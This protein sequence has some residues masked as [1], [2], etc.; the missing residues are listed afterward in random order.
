MWIKA[1]ERLSVPETVALY[2]IWTENN[3]A[4]LGTVDD[5]GDSIRNTRETII[6]YFTGFLNKD[7]I[8]AIFPDVT[9]ENI[10]RLGQNHVIYSGY[11]TFFLTKDGMTS[12]VKAKFS[13]VYIRKPD[14]PHLLITTHNSG[15]TPK[16]VKTYAKR[17]SYSAPSSGRPISLDKVRE[18]RDM[19]IKAVESR[20]V[21]EMVAL[22]DETGVLLG[23]VDDEENDMRNNKE[24][25]AEYFTAFLD[26]DEIMTSFPDVT[27]ENIIRLGQNHVIYSGYY[28]FFLTKDDIITEVKAK[29]SYVY[30]RKPGVPHLL[31]TTHNSGITPMGVKT[32]EKSVVAKRPAGSAPTQEQ[33]QAIARLNFKK[34]NDALQTKDHRAVAALYSSD[35]LSFL[36]TVSAS[37]IKGSS[38]TE[39]YFKAFVQRNPF[40]TITHDT[41]QAYDNGN[42]YLHSGMYTFGLGSGSERKPVQA[43]FS[44]VWKKIGKEWKITHHH[45]SI[46]PDDSQSK[47]TI[48]DVAHNN[49]RKWNEALQTKDPE[50]I[51]AFYSSTLLSFLPLVS[52]KHISEAEDTEDY[53]QIFVQK[54]PFGVITDD[55]VQTFNNGT[56]YLHSGL[57]TFEMSDAVDAGKKT[58]VSARFSYVWTKEAEDWKI[59]HHHS[60]LAPV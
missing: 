43:R 48:E 37:H 40:G 55:S 20:S 10:I 41:V 2:D 56:T 58:P 3:A 25:I 49:F 60:S 27:E 19:W 52:S 4:L 18:A 5:E 51:S 1:V 29:F 22:Y 14:V 17:P 26:R 36:P 53:F 7:E 9:E 34:W 21:A 11:Y 35:E 50:K 6:E 38:A 42:A 30:V 46:R 33:M 32:Y 47:K 8:M 23:T 12:E 24:S 45:S 59:T 28:T 44:Y 13:Y 31:I 39:D 16:G 15:I 57:Y 54:N